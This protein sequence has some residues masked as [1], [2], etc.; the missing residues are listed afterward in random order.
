M[1]TLRHSDHGFYI[2]VNIFLCEAISDR[3]AYFTGDVDLG[4]KL[5]VDVQ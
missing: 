4:R 3:L 5:P 1:N 2:V